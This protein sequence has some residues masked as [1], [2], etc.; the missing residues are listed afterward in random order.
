MPVQPTRRQFLCWLTAA[1]MTPLLPSVRLRGRRVAVIGAGAAGLA[2]AR[3]LAS[4][5]LD[6]VIL[7]AR[8]RIGGR[9]LTSHD[10]APHPVELGAEFIHG[11]QVITWDLLDE[12]GLNHTLSA[13]EYEDSLVF[14]ADGKVWPYPDWL[15]LPAVEMLDAVDETVEWVA[16]DASLAEW[17]G[18]TIPRLVNN[19]FASDYGADLDQLG[20]QGYLEATYA[21]DGDGDFRLEEGYSHLIEAMAAGLTIRLSSPVERIEYREN[22]ATVVLPN[23]RLDVDAV[24]VTLTLAILKAGDVVFDPPL[25]AP[26]QQAVERLGAGKVNKLILKFDS[27]FWDANMEAILTE[28]DTQIWWRP[29]WGRD[30][31]AAILT[32]L[33]GGAAGERFSAMSEAEAI[34]AGLADLSRMFGVEDLAD[35]LVEG[36]FINWGADRYSRMGYSYVPVGAAG[37]RAILA[38]PV[39]STLYFAGEATEV[40]R[41]ATVHGAILSGWRAAE[42]VLRSLG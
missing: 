25:P 28:L 26:K 35:R 4:A 29:G 9:V 21:G 11:D 32:A 39:G 37:M 16:P 33:I 27:P 3:R 5:G 24:V 38:E 7:E 15:S 10:L 20:V 40:S 14:Y 30:R 2:A 17:W 31:E 18:S 19:N 8:D 23:E 41:P 13:L 1:M 36:R 34:Q 42:E 12:L 6:V 22:S